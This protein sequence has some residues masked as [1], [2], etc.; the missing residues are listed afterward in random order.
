MKRRGPGCISHFAAVGKILSKS[1]GRGNQRPKYWTHTAH[2]ARDNR[3]RR[4]EGKGK[5]RIDTIES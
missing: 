5:G 2:I 1:K 3:G 4:D